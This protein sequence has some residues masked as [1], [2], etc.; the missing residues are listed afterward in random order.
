[1]VRRFALL[2]EQQ[3]KVLRWVADGCLDGAWKDF[4]YKRTAYALAD[5]GLVTVDRRRHTWRATI[6]EGGRFYLNQGIYRDVEAVSSRRAAQA[7]SQSAETATSVSRPAPFVTAESLL[8]ELSSTDGVLKVSDPPLRVRAAYRS[9]ISRA[10]A[11]GLVPHGCGLRHTG[12]DGDDL[13]IRLVSLEDEPARARHLSAVPVPVT[14]QGRHQA[15]MALRDSPDLLDVSSDARQRALQ[16]AEAIAAECSR[17]GYGFGLRD[18]DE[19]SFQITVGEDRFCFT[20][21]EELD[22][23]E[24][25]DAEKLAAARYAWQRVPA[26]L[27]QVPSGRLVLRLGSGYGSVSW[28]DRKRWTLD[29][30]LPAVFKQVADRASAQVEE[31]T[32][33][34]A[35]RKQRR[36]AWEE[37]VPR[38]RQAYID[39]FNQDR[40]RK[41]AARSSEAEAIRAY[42]LRLDSAA[43]EYG[44]TERAEQI[45]KW[46][47]WARQEADRIDPVEKPET[48]TFV[49][50]PEVRPSD[51]EKFMPK[52]LSAWRPPD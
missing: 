4:S 22:R 5:R 9:A 11:D 50:P 15:V 20:L 29:Q 26:S 42:C 38:A 28:A 30:K 43:E 25:A 8:A 16:I 41:Q 24:V 49:V 52:G 33:K 14:V 44:G 48:L 37:A 6:T 23:R 18:D 35:E 1:M 3:V 51:F 12:R 40:L 2:S 13:V 21:S 47:S 39:R 19:P 10:I 34:E 31:R 7:G 36:E 27:R 46:A 17:R 32:R 45:R